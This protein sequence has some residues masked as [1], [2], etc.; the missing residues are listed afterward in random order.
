MV[1]AKGKGMKTVYRI[2]VSLL[3]GVMLVSCGGKNSGSGK[4]RSSGLPDVSMSESHVKKLLMKEYRQWKG[5]PHVMGG[6]TKKGVD[7]SGFIHQVYKRVL[8]VAVP[9]STKLLMTTGGRIKKKQLKPGDMVLFKPPT[10]PRHVGIYVGND[11]FIHASKSNGV[12]ITDLKNP[13][14]KK[15]YYSARRVFTR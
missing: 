10:Y 6:N 12:T 15:C 1:T 8:G 5:T 7:C 3:I 14:W 2:G 13:Y 4:S 9:R 11:K